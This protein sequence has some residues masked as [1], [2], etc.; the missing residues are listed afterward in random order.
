MSIRQWKE[1]GP[2]L[3]CSISSIVNDCGQKYCQ[4]IAKAYCFAMGFG[5]F[6]LEGVVLRNPL[7]LTF[8]LYYFLIRTILIHNEKHT[9]VCINDTELSVENSNNH[10]FVLSQLCS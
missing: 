9:G 8:L 2:N 6:R 3:N 1:K 10:T 4:K 7:N 5:D